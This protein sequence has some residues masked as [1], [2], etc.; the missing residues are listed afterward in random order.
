MPQWHCLSGTCIS[1]S[2]SV[3]ILNLYLI[4]NQL[5]Y[6]VADSR[7]DKNGEQYYAADLKSVA[8]PD[9]KSDM[10]TESRSASIC[11]LQDAT[12]LGT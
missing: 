8:I 10:A 1:A 2:L 3:K 7:L 9:R 11:N 12:G 6:I 4:S 5:Q